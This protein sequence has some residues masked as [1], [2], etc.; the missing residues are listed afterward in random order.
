[1]NDVLGSSFKGSEFR[2]PEQFQ[3]ERSPAFAR[4]FVLK[5]EGKMIGWNVPAS[6]TAAMEWGSEAL[7]TGRD[8]DRNVWFLAQ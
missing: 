2:N 4:Y 5:D 6:E 7:T 8:F 1:M 3:L